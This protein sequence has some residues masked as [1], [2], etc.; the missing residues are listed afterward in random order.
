MRWLAL[1]LAVPLLFATVIACGGG[2][3]DDD[4][5]D[6]TPTQSAGDDDDRDDGDAVDKLEDVDEATIRI[7]ASGT[8]VDFEFGQQNNVAGSGS[9]FFIT[10]DGIAV[11]N[12]HVVT[13]AAFLE[14]YVHGDD[15]PR[16]ARV[17]GVSECSDLAVI[18]VDGDGYRYLR[19]YDGDVESG[20]DI[21]AAGFPLGVEEFTLL[22]G[23]V[24]RPDAG[25][26]TTWSSV[27]SVIE[28]TADTLPG[29]SGG[30]IV[31]ADGEVLAVNYAGDQQGRAFAIGRDEALAVID[32]LR[33]GEDITSIGVNGAATGGADW[34]GVWVA[35]VESGSPA[36]DAGIRGGDIITRMEGLVLA[37]DGTMEDYCDILRSHIP[38]DPLAVEVFRTG[39]SEI[40]EGTLNGNPL[41]LST[42]FAQNV[43]DDV[44]DAPSTTTGYDEY[45]EVT[46]DSG[47][48]VMS[49]PE[50]WG[51]VS[52]LQW[53][54]DD[55]LIG[56]SILAATDIDA[57]Y[58]W[59]SPG[60]FFGASAELRSTYSPVQLLDLDR[61]DFGGSCEYDGRYDYSD[62]LYTGVYD[63]WINCSTT[64]GTFIVLTAE[65]DDGSFIILLQ[66][67]AL[68][69]DDLDAID[70]VLDTFLADF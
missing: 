46:D 28:H 56:Y 51:D 31:T 54:F 59:D 39:T 5:D 15:E 14:V 69:D 9:G 13:G 21:Y 50:A 64:G 66:A 19:W 35:S 12:N 48:L 38:T 17:L 60:V 61:N 4:D 27:E 25:G 49:I 10:E 45:F 37:A 29:S 42:S 22:D 1:L 57:W 20:I 16:N 2:G 34:S 70:T 63:V 62:P 47:Q 36:Y 23:I 8:F 67:L 26:E 3:D 41:E 7:V 30:P 53:E 68:Y 33:E 52:G 18:D 55:R 32:K 44:Q 11:T 58:D 65:P 6:V 43:N 40:L 24:S